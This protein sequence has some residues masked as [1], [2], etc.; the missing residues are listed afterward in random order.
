[1]FVGFFEAGLHLPYSPLVG[2]VLRYYTL[3][4]QHLTSNVVAQ[5]WALKWVF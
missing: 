4:I 5:L 3:E 1:M 2:E